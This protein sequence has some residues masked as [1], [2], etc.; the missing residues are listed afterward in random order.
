MNLALHIMNYEVK[1]LQESTRRVMFLRA[2]NKFSDS[3]CCRA[4]AVHPTGYL[5]LDG[6]KKGRKPSI[7][8]KRK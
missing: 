4:N 6:P 2:C 7:K 1:G 5:Q 3:N 8:N